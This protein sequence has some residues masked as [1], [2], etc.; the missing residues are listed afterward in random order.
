VASVALTLAWIAG[1]LIVVQAALLSGYFLFLCRFR[2]QP[3]LLDQDCPRAAVI[4]CVRGLDPFLP[5]CL[6]GLFDQDYPNFDVW[7]VVDSTRDPAWPVINKLAARAAR[8]NVRVLALTERLATS[9]RKIA[10]MLQAMSQLDAS[11][12]IVA[13]LDS[14]VTPHRAWLRELAAPLRE[15]RVGVSSGNRWYM[16]SAPTVGSLVRYL[17]NVAAVVQMYWYGIG[18]GGSLALKTKLL[19]QSGLRQLLS[20]AFG[21]DTT[22]C[23]CAR[24]NGYRIAFSPALMMV[25]RETCTVRGVFGFLERQLLAVRLHNPS[26]WAVA[27]HGVATTTV[28]GATCLLGAAALATGQFSA[29]AW[30]G[31][32]FA[33]YWASMILLL[34]PLEW[35]ARRIVR[36]RGE[37]V[38]G[39]GARGWLAAV[40]AIPLA[41]VVHFSALC[42]AFFTRTH[43]W[44][45][46]Q[47]QFYGPTTT[48]RVIEDLAEAA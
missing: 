6:K 31:G 19:R 5:A 41:Q 37:A 45:G 10:C 39:F 38:T 30:A 23:Q 44:R 1:G 48:V 28:L 8:R 15:E 27:G 2:R 13:L 18:W 24:E 26:W 33:A 42:V 34:L 36:N 22:I 35:C 21:D 20:N 3:A 43:R 4:L 32:A 7:I 17:W 14:D 25:N 29:A 9:S 12:E 46:V 40:F 47:Y 11:H 16:P